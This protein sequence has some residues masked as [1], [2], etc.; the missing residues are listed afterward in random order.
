MFDFTPLSAQHVLLFAACFTAAFIL[1]RSHKANTRARFAGNIVISVIAIAASFSV[2]DT[3]LRIGLLAA[4][5]ITFIIGTIDELYKLSSARQLAAQ[6]VIAAIVVA[7]GWVIQYVSNPW[8]EGVLQ[9]PWLLG[10]A[11]TIAWLVFLMNSINWLD[12][13]DGLSS[14]VGTVAFFVLAAVSLLPSTQD[15]TTLTLAM[16]GAGVLGAFTLWNWPP[17]KVYLGTSGSWF[18]GLYLGLV[19]I[20][21]G[22]K[23]ATTLLVLALPTIDFIAVIIQRLAVGQPPWQGDQVLHLH[24]RLRS[25]GFKPA[26]ISLLAVVATTTF[27]VAAVA[28]HTRYKILFLLGIAVIM[29]TITALIWLYQRNTSHLPH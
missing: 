7:S 24:H 16:I 2:Q 15:A 22:G 6:I 18:L 10:L 27:G 5:I 23:I 20:V 17:A 29:T 11:I 19:A 25:A 28:L 12:G 1:L 3:S 26:T 4:A 9:L 21:G 13:V 8:G 14:S